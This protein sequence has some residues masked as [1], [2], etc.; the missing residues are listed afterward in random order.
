M[1]FSINAFIGGIEV[2]ID[3]RLNIIKSNVMGNGR[4]FITTNDVIWLINMVE[5]QQTEI[6]R[7]EVVEQAYEAWKL[8]K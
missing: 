6:K 7:L 1:L 5:E 8:A 3:T 2:D 4:H